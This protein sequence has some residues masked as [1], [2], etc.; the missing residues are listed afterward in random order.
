MTVFSLIC[1]WRILFFTD[2]L[3]MLQYLEE[4]KRENLLKV[5]KDACSFQQCIQ[6]RESPQVIK[7]GTHMLV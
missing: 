3:S 2:E 6:S 7:V 1:I 4:T 5:K